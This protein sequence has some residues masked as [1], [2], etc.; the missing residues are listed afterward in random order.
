[1][2]WSCFCCC[3]CCCYPADHKWLKAPDSG[4]AFWICWKVESLFWSETLAFCFFQGALWAWEI[5]R[6][7]TLDLKKLAK[8]KSCPSYLCKNMGQLFCWCNIKHEGQQAPNTFRYDRSSCLSVLIRIYNWSNVI[9]KD[10]LILMVSYLRQGAGPKISCPSSVFAYFH[11]RNHFYMSQNNTTM[12]KKGEKTLL[13]RRV[14][15]Q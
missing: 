2:L 10:N 14:T 4:A 15:Y 5:L 8:G 9:I 13:L 11:R 6:R 1:M 3:C 12:L 7:N